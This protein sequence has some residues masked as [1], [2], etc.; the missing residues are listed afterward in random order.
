MAVMSDS[1]LSGQRTGLGALCR[2]LAE[3]AQHDHALLG[4]YGV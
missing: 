3:L 1:D 2:T 4:T